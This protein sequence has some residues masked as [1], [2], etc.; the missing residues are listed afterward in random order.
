[1]KGRHLT[2]RWKSFFVILGEVVTYRVYWG[3]CL[4]IF[5]VCG[6]TYFIL[7]LHLRGNSWPSF[8][9]FVRKALRN[10]LPFMDTRAPGSLSFFG[11]PGSGA[12]GQDKPAVSGLAGQ[13]NQM[14][15]QHAG[16]VILMTAGIPVKVKPAQ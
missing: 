15:P 10:A 6:D 8:Q 11:R 2:Y 7:V 3:G 1:M 12:C 14:L 5:P 13:G 9:L 16:E 4:W